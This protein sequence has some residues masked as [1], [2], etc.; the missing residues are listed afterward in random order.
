MAVS[1]GCER[2]KGPNPSPA[3]RFGII[4][5]ITEHFCD[6]CNRVRLTAAG[7]L[8]ACLGYDDAAPLRDR[9]RAGASDDELRDVIWGALGAKRL[10]HEFASTGAGAPK[11][12]M[13]S[14]GG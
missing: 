2:R 10:G 3:R 6:D 7:D 14:I 12:H 8:H 9:M 1:N 5:A 4:S 13:V 11:K